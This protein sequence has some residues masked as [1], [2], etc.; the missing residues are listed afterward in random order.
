MALEASVGGKTSIFTL[1]P[2]LH[3]DLCL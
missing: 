3:S 1:T 2:C